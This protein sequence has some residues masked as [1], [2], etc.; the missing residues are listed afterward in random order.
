MNTLH[1]HTIHITNYTLNITQIT[2][3]YYIYTHYTL[4]ITHYKKHRLHEHI[5]YT[6]ITDYKL[7][8]TY[9]TDYMNTLHIHTLHITNYTLYITQITGLL[10]WVPYTLPRVTCFQDY[11]TMTTKHWTDGA[12]HSLSVQLQAVSVR[13]FTVKIE[14]PSCTQSIT[15]RMLPVGYQEN[16]AR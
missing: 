5:T 9:N 14:L 11:Y 8:I 15:Q 3:T 16:M 12:F 1:I 4:Q 2:W 13:V 7:H 6:H 10:R